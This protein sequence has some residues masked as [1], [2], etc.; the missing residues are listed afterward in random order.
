MESPLADLLD[1]WGTTEDNGREEF[2]TEPYGL[3]FELAAAFAEMLGLEWRYSANSWWY[4]G[5]TFRVSFFPPRDAE[6]PC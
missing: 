2:V 6:Q 5:H 1:H 4:P 3:N